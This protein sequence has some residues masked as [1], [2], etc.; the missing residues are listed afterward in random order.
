MLAQHVELEKKEIDVNPH[1]GDSKSTTIID[2]Y[3]FRDG[4]PGV[5]AWGWGT[6]RKYPKNLSVDD[7]AK[8]FVE[9]GFKIIYDKR[10]DK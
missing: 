3:V 2:L 9:N 7:V 8:Q 5:E 10:D 6:L 4:V 1:S